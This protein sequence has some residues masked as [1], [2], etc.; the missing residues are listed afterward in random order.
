[1]AVTIADTAA[2]KT[3]WYRG[4]C[5]ALTEEEDLMS[6]MRCLT[7][8]MRLAM[9]RAISEF[10]MPPKPVQRA[11]TPVDGWLS[12]LVTMT[13]DELGWRWQSHDVSG[14]V[15]KYVGGYSK[16]EH[17]ARGARRACGNDVRITY[18]DGRPYGGA[19]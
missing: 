17:C 4:T 19:R 16:P 10:L 13:K 15:V 3:A 7:P 1:M 2:P 14:R 8:D 12:D 11:S 9:Q 5:E 6:D 18:A